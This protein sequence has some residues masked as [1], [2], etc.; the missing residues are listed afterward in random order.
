[1]F[2]GMQDRLRLEAGIDIA[3]LSRTRFDE[4]DFGS[5]LEFISH[6]QFAW[7]VAERLTAGYRFQHM[8]NAGL[9]ARN[10]GLNLHFLS[11]EYSF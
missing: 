9:N 3:V 2:H 5:A 4:V 6:V 11:L 7:E 10:P 8:S 1:M